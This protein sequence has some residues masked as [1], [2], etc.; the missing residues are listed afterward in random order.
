MALEAPNTGSGRLN[1]ALEASNTGSGG[2]IWPWRPQVQ[3]VRDGGASW[4]HTG[5]TGRGGA[6]WVHT[7][8]TGR[9]YTLGTHAK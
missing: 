7:G 4:V 9:G 8:S 3:V 2:R 1:M 5:S 6:S